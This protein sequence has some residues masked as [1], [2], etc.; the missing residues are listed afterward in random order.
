MTT[1]ELIDRVLKD[2]L[3]AGSSAVV[4]DTQLRERAWFG[5]TK[6][7]KKVWDAAPTWWRLNSST[8]VLSSGVGTMPTDF[9]HMGDQGRLYVSGMYGRE[10]AYRPPDEVKYLITNS[11]QS[12]TPYVYTLLD[13]T[14]AGVPKILCYPTDSSTLVL[15]TYVREMPELIDA[16]MA[17]T[18]TVTAVA[19]NPNGTYTYRCTSVT[20]DGE[21]EG[22]QIS[23]SLATGGAFKVSLLVPKISYNPRSIT[24]RK[25][26]RTVTTGYQHKLV[27]SLTI[28]TAPLDQ[29]Y[30]YTDNTLDASL[31]DNVP[32]PGAAVSG[33]EKFPAQFHESALYDGLRAFLSTGAGDGR[34]GQFDA[35]WQYAVR[36]QW[37]EIQQGQSENWA[38]PAFPGYYTGHPV[39]SRFSMS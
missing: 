16:P 11:P 24:S 14:S 28:A 20:A 6:T 35:K 23:T 8:V 7:A 32:L 4:Q 12:G 30:T 18:P 25:V 1:A 13:H 31:T 3:N 29:D 2:Y 19:G 26:Y 15:T 36:R 22:G 38:F 27:A 9:S 34:E 33:I 39:W 5:L 17:P 21:T 10:L 37:E